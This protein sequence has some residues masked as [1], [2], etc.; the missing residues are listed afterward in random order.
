[1][2]IDLAIELLAAAKS[3]PVEDIYVVIENS[4][5]IGYVGFN[6]DNGICGRYAD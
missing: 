2:Q 3:E 4:N 6:N 1:M 5:W